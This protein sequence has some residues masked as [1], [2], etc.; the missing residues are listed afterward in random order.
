MVSDDERRRI[1][2]RLR[3]LRRGANN[4]TQLNHG[5]TWSLAWCVLGDGLDECG[6]GDWF[7]RMC[8]RLADLIEPGDTSQSCRDSVACDREAPETCEHW[9][10]GECYALR[11]VRPVDRETLLALAEEMTWCYEGAASAEGDGTVG[12]WVV[13]SYADRI[14]EACGE[15]V[16]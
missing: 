16:R 4:V 6:T 8:A 3:G 2:E 14:R 10:D 13:M 15:V 7:E 9:L 1:A 5:P 12:A 11:T